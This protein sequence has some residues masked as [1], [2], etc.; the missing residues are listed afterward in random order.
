MTLTELFTGIANAIRAKTGSTATLV[1]T[2]FASAISGIQTGSNLKQAEGSLVSTSS[3]SS[4]MT[5]NLA[6]WSK[7]HHMYITHWYK[8]DFS[9]QTLDG[10]N[11]CAFTAG[12][13]NLGK[14]GSSTLHNLN[15]TL[16]NRVM[17]NNITISFSSS[18][19]LTI[20][21]IGSGSTNYYYYWCAVGE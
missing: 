17:P 7:I 20:N 14:G 19:V 5:I 21:K 18:S 3:F 10:V 4:N 16:G 11:L 6:G 13:I 12:D 15:T 1:P 8:A 2:N 9:N